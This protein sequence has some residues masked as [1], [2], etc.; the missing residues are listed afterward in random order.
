MKVKRIERLLQLIQLLQS[1]HGYT[2]R[3]LADR[4]SVSRRTIFRDLELLR[5]AGFPLLF[6]EAEGR[7]SLN[8]HRLLPATNFTAEEVLSLL[9]LCQE[10][11]PAL[12]FQEPAARAALKLESSLPDALRQELAGQATTVRI[13]L[14]AMNPLAGFDEM[15]HQLRQALAQHRSVRIRYL[16][17]S[18]AEPICTRLNPY[19]LLFSRRAWYVIG[20]SSLH[21]ATRTFHVG[22]I[23]HL[24][25]LDDVFQVPRGFSLR[26][27]LRNAWHLIPERGPDYDVVLRFR[28]NVARTVA[29]VQWHPTQQMRWNQDGS[30]DFFVTVSGLWEIS[31]WVLGYGDQVEVLRPEELRELIVRRAQSM[32]ALYRRAAPPVEPPPCDLS[33]WQRALRRN[34]R[35]TRRDGK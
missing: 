32:L 24:E 2:T 13:Q 27:Y 23:Q 9:V 35:A 25:V 3:T 5:K 21:R 1:G 19:Q 28:P 14:P 34:T 10:L 12:P 7:F 8:G 11:G 16:G 22:R 33:D 26:R 31:W 30:L 4:C 29:E 15:F 17:S 20:R 6:D 18:D